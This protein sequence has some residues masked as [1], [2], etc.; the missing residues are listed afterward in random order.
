MNQNKPWFKFIDSRGSA[1]KPWIKWCDDMLPGDEGFENPPGGFWCSCDRQTRIRKGVRGTGE[2]QR[3]RK[4]PASTPHSLTDVH[5]RKEPPTSLIQVSCL[6]EGAVPFSG[7]AKRPEAA[8]KRERVLPIVPVPCSRTQTHSKDRY[9]LPITRKQP[10]GNPL[11][12]LFHFAFA[13]SPG[14]VIKPRG[15][16]RRALTSTASSRSRRRHR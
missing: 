5:I 4:T 12:A 6:G 7:V 10:T 2:R 13:L 9:S 11:F 8:Y 16:R 1:S 15:F 14:A 3:E